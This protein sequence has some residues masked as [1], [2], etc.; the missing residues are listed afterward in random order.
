MRGP[1]PGLSWNRA[2]KRG[3]VVVWLAGSGGRRRKHRFKASNEVQARAIARTFLE[4]VRREELMAEVAPVPAPVAAPSLPPAPPPAPEKGLTVAGLFTSHLERFL[5]RKRESTAEFYGAVK[6]AVERDGILAEREL[7]SFRKPDIEDF[8]LRLEKEGRSSTTAAGYGAALVCLLR[9]AVDRDLLEEFPIKKRIVYP[10]RQKPELEL[11]PEE[12]CQLL[13]AFDEA[14]FRERLAADDTLRGFRSKPETFG[15]LQ[16]FYPLLLA[17][18]RT[19]LRKGDLLR[20]TWGHVNLA[21]GWIE[22]VTAK[23]GVPVAVGI[24]PDLAAVLTQIRPE[25]PA[26]EELVFRRQDGEPWTEQSVKDVYA[27][28][29]RVAGIKRRLR[30]HDAT[31]HTLG[32]TLVTGGMTL[33]EVAAV[34]G[35][36][37]YRSTQRYARVRSRA[38]RQKF[39]AALARHEAEASAPSSSPAVSICTPSAPA[40]SLG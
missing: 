28:A 1:V 35:H 29:K 5:E 6:K 24:A 16:A 14:Y 23:K 30:F 34:L 27:L 8:M 25:S 32:S 36:R 19:G 37:D 40:P 22:L 26:P 18:M 7:Q 17:G 4:Q 39:L 15:R 2:T 21:E 38:V 12:E 20:L 10:T 3:E 13:A 33:E 31:R 11:S 9:W